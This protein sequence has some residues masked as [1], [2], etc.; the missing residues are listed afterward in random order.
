MKSTIFN[1]AEIIIRKIVDEIEIEREREKMDT[2]PF[3]DTNGYVAKSRNHILSSM[4][5]VTPTVGSVLATGLGLGLIEHTGIYIGDGYVIEQ[6]GDDMLKKVTL[7][8]FKKGDGEFYARGLNSEIQ[9]AC[10]N[11]GVPLA[12][13]YVAKNAI[14][15][16]EDYNR[17]TKEYS[18]IFN[19]CHQFTWECIEPDADEQLVLFTTLEQ[20]ISQKYNSVLYWDTLNIK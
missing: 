11:K 12:N 18:I 10:N 14:K 5:T 6:H 15:M 1:V 3:S 16:Y 2:Q 13:E 9:I 4:R 17:R 19:N 20:K 8:E 7:E